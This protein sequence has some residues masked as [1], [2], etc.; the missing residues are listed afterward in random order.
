MTGR[1]DRLPSVLVLAQDGRTAPLGALIPTFT[2]MARLE[3]ININSSRPRLLP[4]ILSEGCGA[5]KAVLLWYKKK[6]GK[7]APNLTGGGA[8][9][10]V[11]L[12]YSGEEERL[13]I[14]KKSRKGEKV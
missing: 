3:S 10:D 9:R 12:E 14:G 6:K 5:V 4:I 11:N 7:E 13:S 2:Y 1:D 8:I